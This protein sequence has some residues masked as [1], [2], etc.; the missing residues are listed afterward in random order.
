MREWAHDKILGEVEADEAPASGD[1]VGE[2]GVDGV[3]REREVGE[4]RQAAERDGEGT[5]EC[6]AVEDD[7]DDGALAVAG[8]S[9]PVAGGGGGGPSRERAGGIGE[10]ELGSLQVENLLV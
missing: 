2:G 7:R 10:G 4:R 6:G 9:G 1:G 3:V 5:G 8:D